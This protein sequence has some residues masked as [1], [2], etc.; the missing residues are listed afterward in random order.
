MMACLSGP[1]NTKLQF[2]YDNK[3]FAPDTLDNL[4]K[5]Q[6]PRALVCYIDTS[7][8]GTC[9]IIPARET[10]I[11]NVTEF[12]SSIALNLQLEDF[13]F[14]DNGGEVTDELLRM[15]LT[16]LP[17]VI[18]PG[19]DAKP[20]GGFLIYELS[21]YPKKIVVN[22][23]IATWEKTIKSLHSFD[24]F[25]DQKFFFHIPVLYN[26]MPPKNAVI[27]Q[28]Q[29]WPEKLKLNSTYT[30]TIIIFHPS[31]DL[32]EINKCQIKI[33]SNVKTFAFNPEDLDVDSLYDIR[34]WSFKVIQEN[35]LYEPNG[36]ITVSPVN[37]EIQETPLWNLT[38]PF[39]LNRPYLK[40]S[41]VILVLGLLIAMP[42]CIAFW[43]REVLV[44]E[45]IYAAVMFVIF[46]MATATAA[47]FGIKKVT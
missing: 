5:S 20:S 36:W 3:L 46:G 6:N 8:R 18:E 31:K 35:M 39:K 30:L 27:Q 28:S 26:N 23:S 44:E 11:Q 19:N 33:N 7:R 13:A 15:G 25:K 1:P 10:I 47:T 17:E 29:L 45:K 2:R 24:V 4:R 41:L 40:L 12:G 14:A 9:P 34:F 21:S 37:K 38:L 22:R 32:G 43:N 16:D 42:A